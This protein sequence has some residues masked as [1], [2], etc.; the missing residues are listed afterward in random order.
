MAVAICLKSQPA[1][2]L[3]RILSSASVTDRELFSSWWAGQRAVNPLPLLLTFSRREVIW[4]IVM[5]HDS[6]PFTL[7]TRDMVRME[8]HRQP[9]DPARSSL[10]LKVGPDHQRRCS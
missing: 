4:S 3:T 1:K 10:H 8:W 5:L 2:H 7:H 9:P 6:Y